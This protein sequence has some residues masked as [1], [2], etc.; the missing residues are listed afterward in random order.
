MPSKLFLFWNIKIIWTCLE[1]CFHNITT[2][3][4]FYKHTLIENSDQSYALV[5]MSCSK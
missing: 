1:K 5:A 2:V 3:I 4:G